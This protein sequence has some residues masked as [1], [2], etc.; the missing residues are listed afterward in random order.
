MKPILTLAVRVEQD[1]V[2]A[3]QRA[4]EIAAMVG[5]RT[6]DQTRI[7]TAVSEIAR[8]AFAYA[9][10]GT[11]KFL[12]EGLAGA[13]A[14]VARIS[15]RGPGIADLAAV[16]EGRFAS[17]TGMG[18]G[19]IGVRRIMH[20]FRIESAPNAGTSVDIGRTLP[21]DAP[22]FTPALMAKMADELARRT[23]RTSHEEVLQQNQ[24]LIQVLGELRARQ[25]ELVLTNR[26]LED[27]Y[28][29]I[30]ALYRELEDKADSL[31][32]AGDE[33]ARLLANS[34]HEIRTPLSAIAAIADLLLRR[35][36]GPLTA[37][38][39]R[40]VDLI[41]RAAREV[42]DLVNDLLVLAK[43]EAGRVVI[44]PTRGS[45]ESLFAELRGMLRPL[46]SQGRVDLVFDDVSDLP[47]LR[48][49]LGKIAQILRNL[50]TNALKCTREGTV[51]VSAAPTDDGAALRLTVSDTGVGISE[52]DL[53]RI[54]EEFVQ[55][56]DGLLAAQGVGL[57]LPVSRRLAELLGGEITV[58]SRVG[59]GS[60]FVVTVP[61]TYCTT[62]D[63]DT[64]VEIVE[65]APARRSDGL[66]TDTD[67]NGHRH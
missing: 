33:K 40:Q 4:R 18:L 51:R 28:H 67:R 23:L 2:V 46:A 27:S 55:I 1:I 34:S 62:P 37:E 66:C 64:V 38:Q 52:A 13:R 39:E 6:Q 8:N 63:D 48:T 19:L 10:G 14:L 35:T 57:G 26:A 65:A 16:L 21:P 58:R 15:D 11:V 31:R 29:G 45:V 9:G 7:A 36:D 54:F 61:L 49:D 47:S 60:T 59:E 32:R 25:D 44:R 3:R 24:E 41:R 30:S 43:M 56:G 12:L 53:D 22:E 50:I 5:F 42:T 17:R 20:V